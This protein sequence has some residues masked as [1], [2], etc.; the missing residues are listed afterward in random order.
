MGKAWHALLGNVIYGGFALILSLEVA[1]LEVP[2]ENDAPLFFPDIDPSF[3]RL[4]R[5]QGARQPV[6]DSVAS[7]C[8][9]N[10]SKN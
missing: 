7:S 2:E 6:A 3:V 5:K 8:T 9:S 4:H 1:G 10:G